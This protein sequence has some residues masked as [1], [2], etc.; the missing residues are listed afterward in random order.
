MVP[1]T[2]HSVDPGSGNAVL[3]HLQESAILELSYLI[4]QPQSHPSTQ[5]GQHFNTQLK[6]LLFPY[7]G[8]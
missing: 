8:F 2:G 6:N 5:I 3:L 1:Q 7:C 4:L